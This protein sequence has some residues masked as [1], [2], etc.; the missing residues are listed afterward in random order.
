MTSMVCIVD[1]LRAIGLLP[2]R[3]WGVLIHSHNA[4]QYLLL[5]IW[6]AARWVQS[7][8]LWKLNA[9]ESIGA[10]SWFSC[11]ILVVL[12][13]FPSVT[14]A[15]KL[16]VR[17]RR[18][19]FVKLQKQTMQS[20]KGWSFQNWGCWKPRSWMYVVI[21]IDVTTIQPM[22]MTKRSWIRFVWIELNWWVLTNDKPSANVTSKLVT[23]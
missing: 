3:R 10:G 7:K 19:S 14:A 9:T 1:R 6:P 8:A 17:G 13:A 23:S 11:L 2:M 21:V 16:T 22:M 20:G 12:M 18:F 15:R 5:P 4:R